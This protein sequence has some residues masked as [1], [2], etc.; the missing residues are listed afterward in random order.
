MLCHYKKVMELNTLEFVK[1]VKC[2]YSDNAIY[3]PHDCKN[4][5]NNNAFYMF[6]DEDDKKRNAKEENNLIELMLYKIT[7]DGIFV[8]ELEAVI[9]KKMRYYTII[10]K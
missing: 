9:D 8:C 7:V 6:P 1:L 10:V 5:V 3:Y 4:N 2:T